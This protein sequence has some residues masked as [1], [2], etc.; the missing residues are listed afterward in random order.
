MY[1]LRKGNETIFDDKI[2]PSVVW[3]CDEANNKDELIVYSEHEYTKRYCLRGRFQSS[4]SSNWY[5]TI[6]SKRYTSATQEFEFRLEEP[7]VLTRTLFTNKYTHLYLPQCTVEANM[8]NVF[9][10]MSYLQELDITNVNWSNATNMAYSFQNL[11]QG[12]NIIGL[13]KSLDTMTN[14]QPT[15]GATTFILNGIYQWGIFKYDPNVK[16][17][18]HN[19]Q[20]LTSNCQWFTDLDVL[21]LKNYNLS[22]VIKISNIFYNNPNIDFTDCN[23]K[24]IDMGGSIGYGNDPWTAKGLDDI[25]TSRADTFYQGFMGYR[26]NYP[27]DYQFKWDTSKVKT[28]NQCFCS[29]PENGYGGNR[30]DASW[31]DAS[32]ATNITQMFQ[33]TTAQITSINAA[34]KNIKP[35]QITDGN[36][37]FAQMASVTDLNLGPNFDLTNST[38]AADSD[39]YMDGNDFA[40][41]NKLTNITG[42][43]KIA[44]KHTMYNLQTLNLLTRESI[45]V[46][47][48]GL[49]ATSTNKNFR[50]HASAFARLTEEDIAIATSKGWT[51]TQG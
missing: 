10:N 46:L 17:D 24:P 27:L 20:Y 30:I 31:I 23:L 6:N 34:F 4:T 33:K 38:W 2:A 35:G 19:L 43:I 29:C 40:S 21:V 42:V 18:L 14:L 44:K 7:L 3:V 48:N 11:P 28:F 25:D 32:S 16:L 5:I 47:I 39:S 36:R 41:S 22:G 9:A 45:M 49:P 51:V 12:I 13:Q 37:V 50:L 1:Y 26:G 15:G 8:T